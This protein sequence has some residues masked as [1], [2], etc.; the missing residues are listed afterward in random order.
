MEA[1]QKLTVARMIAL[2][3]FPYL[4]HAIYSLIVRWD[5][6]ALTP[7]EGEDGKL[8]M[9]PTMGVSK[10]GVLFVHPKAVE[11]WAQGE[12][13]AV[14]V[15]EAQHLLRDHNGRRD[16]GGYEPMLWN[17]AADLAINY[18]ISAMCGTVPNDP[19]AHH[20][21]LP[22]PHLDPTNKEI[23]L[24]PG[25]TAEEYYHLLRKQQP[26]KG[27]NGQGQP[28]CGSGS[29][30]P[31]HGEPQDGDGQGVQGRS[32]AE[33][34]SMRRQT[35][36]AIKAE[37]GKNA[38]SIPGDLLRWAED[39]L[40][41]PKVR[42]QDKLAR[43]F[44]SAFSY[45]AG[46]ADYTYS[47]ISR[48]Q[49]GV[50]FGSGRPIL[51][52]MRAPIPQVAVAV[53][54][55]GSMGEEQLREA[56]SEVEGVARAVAAPITFLACDA[57]VHSLA[58]IDNWRQTKNLLKGGGGTSFIPIFEALEARRPKAGLV[59]VLTDGIGPAPASPP[60]G[61][62]VIWILIGGYSQAPATWGEVIKLDD[63]AK[64][65]EV[66]KKKRSA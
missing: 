34:G 25:K 29:G 19:P 33:L 28:C 18:E 32:E 35:A 4:S 36:E 49:W 16:L 23:N 17:C 2:Q 15:H 20:M 59:I 7:G 44:R 63:V 46:M 57:Q 38:G 47:K 26:Q 40:T 21:R 53:D 9:I 10:H 66:Q 8:T 37:A 22:N 11:K 39:Q 3:K 60:Q 1:K 30:N 5:E 55:S 64:P 58:P 41:P 45:R 31:F 48:R 27:K 54:T 52:A 12:V 50:G 51:P 14:L 56:L 62:D 61:T 42:W 6:R 24:P 65:L 13:A 43:C